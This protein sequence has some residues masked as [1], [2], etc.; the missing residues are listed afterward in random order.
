M[1]AQGDRLLISSSNA[2]GG[3]HGRL[4]LSQHYARTSGSGRISTQITPVWGLRA[5]G[6]QNDIRTYPLDLTYPRENPVDRVAGLKRI[7]PAVLSWV[8]TSIRSG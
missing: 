2:A 6:V 3:V 1:S 5:G 4:L 7:V 8:I